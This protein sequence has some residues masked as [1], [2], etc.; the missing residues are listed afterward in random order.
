[1]FL[2]IRLGW[3]CKE[4]SLAYIQPA[5]WLGLHELDKDGE[6]YSSVHYHFSFMCQLFCF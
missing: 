1:M 4:K 6:P 5:R 3:L 2:A